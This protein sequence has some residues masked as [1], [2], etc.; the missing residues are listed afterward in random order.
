MNIKPRISE[1]VRKEVVQVANEWRMKMRVEEENNTVVLGFLLLLVAYKLWSN[2]EMKE[3]QR[4]YKMVDH[5]RVAP[6][7]CL[8]LGFSKVNDGTR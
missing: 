8:R 7:L 5:H 2:F 3:L 1:A 6:Q 4:L